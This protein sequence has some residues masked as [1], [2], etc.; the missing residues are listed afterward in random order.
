[1]FHNRFFLIEPDLTHSPCIMWSQLTFVSTVAEVMLYVAYG[2]I[3]LQ[4]LI[5]GD[6]RVHVAAADMHSGVA[7]RDRSG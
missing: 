1:M 2:R 5:T 6:N 7:G 3:R 4:P